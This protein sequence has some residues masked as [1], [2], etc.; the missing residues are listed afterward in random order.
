MTACVTANSISWIAKG[1]TLHGLLRREN[2]ENGLIPQSC[3]KVSFST[4]I[5]PTYSLVRVP[6][7]GTA[8]KKE[9]RKKRKTHKLVAINAKFLYGRKTL[10]KIKVATNP[11]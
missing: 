9:K 11:I 2:R 8:C 10:K 7:Q 5:E 6:T 4:N 3:S 1:P